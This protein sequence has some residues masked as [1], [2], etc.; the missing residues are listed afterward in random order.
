MDLRRVL[1][2]HTKT[3]LLMCGMQDKQLIVSQHARSVFIKECLRDELNFFQRTQYHVSRLHQDWSQE[4]VK[5]AELQADN[6]RG[7]AEEVETM[8]LG[9]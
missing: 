1:N 8:P 5:Y 7:L 3:A 9:E 2:V 4:L 6:W